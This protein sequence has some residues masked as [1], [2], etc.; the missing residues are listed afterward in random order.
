[1]NEASGICPNLS[2]ETQFRLNKINEIKN[3]FIAKIRERKTVS[4][5][6]SK[7]IAAFEYCDYYF[8]YFNYFC[9]LLQ[10]LIVLSTTSGVISII[11]FSSIIGAPVGGAIASFGFSFSLTTGIIKTFANNKK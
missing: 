9:I 11:S 6:L 10:T 4:K 5:R 8:D 3:Y 2:D 1:M 7:Y